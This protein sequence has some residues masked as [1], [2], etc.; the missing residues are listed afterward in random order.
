MIDTTKQA[1]EGLE[2]TSSP[3][4]VQ[5]TSTGGGESQMPPLQVA[6]VV[7]PS[8]SSSIPAWF[9]LL[10]VVVIVLFVAVTALVL[11]TLG[12]GKTPVTTVS[13]KQLVGEPS[14]AP[15]TITTPIA[16]PTPTD[17]VLV[18]LRTFSASSDVAALTK[19]VT[20]TNVSFIKAT[21][22][23]LDKL[24]NSSP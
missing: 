18:S 8:T 14:P 7:V 13:D 3:R 15:T 20:E 21:L 9:K 24:F 22:T 11:W 12:S 2:V 10:F 17:E 6:P 19:D 23:E 5:D 1:Q 16:S 4:P